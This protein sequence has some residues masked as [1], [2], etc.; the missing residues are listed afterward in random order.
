MVNSPA[1]TLGESCAMSRT[2]FFNSVLQAVVLGVMFIANAGAST[3]CVVGNCDL[4]NVPPAGVVEPIQGPPVL[5]VQPGVLELI[6]FQ[7][8]NGWNYSF[9]VGG[10]DIVS[11]SIPYFEGWNMDQA[12]VVEGWTYQVVKATE[13]QP[14]DLALWTIQNDT[15]SSHYSV[16][17]T[18]LSN[19]APTLAT[20]D[21]RDSVGN[22]FAMNVFIPLTPS[23]IDAGY[24]ATSLP[25]PEPSSALLYAAGAAILL[26]VRRT[27]N[28]TNGNSL[29]H[30]RKG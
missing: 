28:N 7:N 16:G 4:T 24:A 21:I 11:V 29:F 10:S 22:I 5:V 2:K 23:A 17:A 18:F 30:S 20:V 6:P 15:P 9:S 14:T 19:F 13:N 27:K 3:L 26:T 1:S 25:V 12:K 8:L